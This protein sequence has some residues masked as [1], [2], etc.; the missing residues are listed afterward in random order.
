MSLASY[1]CY[2]LAMYLNDYKPTSPTVTYPRHALVVPAGV[3]NFLKN[4][5][6]SE[7]NPTS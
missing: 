5:R 3:I 2:Y 7:K 1:R 4:Y 6:T